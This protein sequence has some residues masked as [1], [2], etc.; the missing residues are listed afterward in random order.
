VKLFL[1]P[2]VEVP[3]NLNGAKLERRRAAWPTC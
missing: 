2:A 3:L 1:E